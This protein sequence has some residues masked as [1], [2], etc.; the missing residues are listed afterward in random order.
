MRTDRKKGKKDLIIEALS[1]EESACFVLIRCDSPSKDGRMDVEFT[2]EGDAS[3]ASY[4]L[5]SAQD[6]LDQTTP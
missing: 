3:L 2:Y 4:L 6:Y 1:D 5:E